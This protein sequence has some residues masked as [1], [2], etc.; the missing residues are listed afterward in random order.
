MKPVKKYSLLQP[1]LPVCNYAKKAGI[2]AIER[3]YENKPDESEVKA[4]LPTR[5][6]RPIRT[7]HGEKMSIAEVINKDKKSLLTSVSDKIKEYL[8]KKKKTPVPNATRFNY[9]E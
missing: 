4:P 7:A 8:K 3:L 5:T 6:E 9:A 1:T 2:S